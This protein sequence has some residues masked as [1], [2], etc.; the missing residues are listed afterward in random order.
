MKAGREQARAAATATPVK[1]RQQKLWIA[2]VEALATRAPQIRPQKPHPQH[3]LYNSIG[4]SGFALNP[5]ANQRENRLGVEL[6][7]RH[8]ESKTMFKAL[9]AQKAAIEKELGFELDWQELPDAHACRI[10]AWRPNSPIEDEAQWGQFIDWYVDRLVKM[11][12]AFRPA[13]QQLP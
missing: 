10:A 1:Q 2:L 8:A 9:H 4:R 12:A 6:Y 5:T 13:I 3:W 7:I 11:N